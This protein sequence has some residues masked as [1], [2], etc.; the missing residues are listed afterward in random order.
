MDKISPNSIKLPDELLNLVIAAVGPHRS[1]VLYRRQPDKNYWQACALVSRRWHRIT[2]PHLFRS[3]AISEGSPGDENDFREFLA[4]KPSIAQLIERVT[5]FT[6][7]L[8]MW[9]VAATLKVLPKLRDLSMIGVHLRL[10]TRGPPLCGEYH[11]Q[12]LTYTTLL[13][14]GQAALRETLWRSAMDLLNLFSDVQ[15]LILNDMNNSINLLHEFN[16]TTLVRFPEEKLDI[17]FMYLPCPAPGDLPYLTTLKHSGA[18]RNLTKLQ[19]SPTDV[20]CLPYLNQQLLLLGPTLEDL[21][22]N[23]DYHPTDALLQLPHFDANHYANMLQS[24]LAACTRLQD[25]RVSIDTD[26]LS[27]GDL[28]NTPSSKY[29]VSMVLAVQDWTFAL[30]IIS[31]VPTGS[32][33]YLTFSH[34]QLF[35]EAV[36]PTSDMDYMFETLPWSML[37]DVGHRFPNIQC[38]E[39]GSYYVQVQD[40]EEEA[41]EQYEARKM[42]WEEYAKNEMREFEDVFMCGHERTTLV[43]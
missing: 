23:Y 15:D 9:T 22:F 26:V 12:K 28:A 36:H 14:D 29:D 37:R 41:A 31:L 24:G 42:K 13:R 32:L 35:D 33:E 34:T 3:I 27:F 1:L 8:H 18:F 25:F 6:I 43:M 5:Y 19:V 17:R 30:E 4:S 7:D 20:D 21:H 2:L 16:N 39:V 11:I 10:K 40:V 38:L